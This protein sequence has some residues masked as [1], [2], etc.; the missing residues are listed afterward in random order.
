[1]QKRWTIRK[2]DAA[3]VQRLATELQVKPLIA[4][5]LIS[6]GHDSTEKAVQFLNPSPEHLHEPLLLKGMREAAD[7]IQRAVANREKILVWGDYDVDGTTGTVLL[8]KMLSML[9]SESVFH[10]PNRF[11]EGYGINIPALEQAHR[12]GV[13]LVISV[14]TGT[15][16]VKEVEFANSIGLDVIITDH[17]LPKT[18]E[19]LPPAVAIVNPNQPGCP[20][21]DKHLAGVGVAF[22]LAHALLR[23]NNLEHEVPGFMKI[24][25]LGTV[26]DMMELTGEN[27]AIV[28]SRFDR[29]AKNGQLRPKGFDGG[30]RLPFGHDKLPYWL[31]HCSAYQCRRTHGCCKTCC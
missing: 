19:E 9:G 8:R 26:A 24:A 17:H 12:D 21:P 5:L 22:K 11:T 30:R 3:A 7:R 6:R 13:S 25:A 18:G 2:H 4:A 20:Y 28:A 29:S 27:R 31:S 16:S 10:V 1:M 14:D 15:T 23:E